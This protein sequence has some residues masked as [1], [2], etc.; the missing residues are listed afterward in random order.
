MLILVKKGVTVN[1]YRHTEVIDL[2]YIKDL[3]HDEL[4]KECAELERH[5]KK[6]DRIA[7]ISEDI[8]KDRLIWVIMSSDVVIGF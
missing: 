6:T 4:K 2:D 3:S 5:G 1:K 8:N 7:L